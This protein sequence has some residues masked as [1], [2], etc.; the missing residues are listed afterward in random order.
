MPELDYA[1]LC[2][3]VRD[4][5]GLSHILA[6]GIDTIHVK[7]LPAGHNM[8]V[9]LRVLFT[10]SECGRPHR[11]EMFIQTEDGDRIAAINATITPEWSEELPVHWYKG[12]QQ[13]LKFGVLL[14]ETGNYSIDILVDDDHKKTIPFRVLLQE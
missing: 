8:A 4:E 6:A 13:G 1:I 11:F 9:A 7:E 12:A 5:G 2:E 10:R 14:P 3:Y